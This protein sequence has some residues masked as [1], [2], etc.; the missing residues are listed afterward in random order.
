MTVNSY[1]KHQAARE[2]VE[3]FVERA[4]EAGG[5]GDVGTAEAGQASNFCAYT[6]E[7][8][9][10]K[11]KHSVEGSMTTIG[12]IGLIFIGFFL[13]IIYLTL[14]GIKIYK[15]GDDGD[16]EEDGLKRNFT[17]LSSFVRDRG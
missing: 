14:Q 16:E 12:T 17:V 10:A 5:V 8:C 4:Y 3:Y 1:S 11:I 13:V 6:D 15:G 7:G 9:K 2:H